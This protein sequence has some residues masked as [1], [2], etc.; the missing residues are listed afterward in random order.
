MRTIE[1]IIV[2]VAGVALAY[3][4]AEVSVSIVTHALDHMA[5]TLNR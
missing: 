3:V 1:Y 5:A 4:V 2:I